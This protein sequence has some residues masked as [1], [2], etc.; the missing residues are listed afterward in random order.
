MS[1]AP[2]APNRQAG[3]LHLPPPGLRGMQWGTMHP[4]LHGDVGVSKVRPEGSKV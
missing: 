2:P 1:S 3:L 4:L